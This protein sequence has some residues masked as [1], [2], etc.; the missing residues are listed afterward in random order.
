MA[1]TINVTLDDKTYAQLCMIAQHFGES[2]EV[3]ARKAMTN[4]VVST[5]MDWNEPAE[6][7]V[8]ELCERINSEINQRVGMDA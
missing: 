2:V 6:V 8:D 4:H 1:R 3:C 5:T 7:P